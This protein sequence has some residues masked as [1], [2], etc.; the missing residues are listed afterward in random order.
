MY[1]IIGVLIGFFIL[2]LK[3]NGQYIIPGFKVGG[4]LSTIESNQFK[5]S[6]LIGYNAGFVFTT[7]LTD[8]FDLISLLDFTRKGAIIEGR[9]TVIL[10]NS[11]ELVEEKL[12]INSYEWSLLGNYYLKVPGFS[13]QAGFSLAKNSSRNK[14]MQSLYFGSTDDGSYIFSGQTLEEGIMDGIDYA[15]IFGISGGTEALKINLSYHAGLKNYFKN[16]DYNNLGYKI[17]CNYIELSISYSLLNWRVVS[18]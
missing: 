14:G 11:T 4:S 8:K 16:I 10:D 12:Y 6:P 18:Y 1:K 9:R 13:I 17:K 7:P 3:C 5:T 2:T 15:A